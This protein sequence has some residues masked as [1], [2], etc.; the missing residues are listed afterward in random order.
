MAQ[1]I[2]S[3]ESEK[4]AMEGASL[5]VDEMIRQG[6]AVIDEQGVVHI[7]QNYQPSGEFE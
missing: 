1:R 6:Q 7:N 2:G 5:I 3:L 4:K